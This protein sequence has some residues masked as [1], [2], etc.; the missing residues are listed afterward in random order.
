[1][2][3]SRAFFFLTR[4][5][6]LVFAPLIVSIISFSVFQVSDDINFLICVNNPPAKCCLKTK[7]NHIFVAFGGKCLQTLHIDESVFALSS[8]E[9]VVVFNEREVGRQHHHL[10]LLACIQHSGYTG[11]GIVLSIFFRVLPQPSD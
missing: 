4:A 10:Y 1:M 9:N 8:S 6:F 5:I 2:L 11:V 7:K 3:P